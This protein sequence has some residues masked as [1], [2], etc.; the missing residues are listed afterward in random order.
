MSKATDREAHPSARQARLNVPAFI[1]VVTALLVVT[2][3]AGF[4]T[5]R[6]EGGAHLPQLSQGGMKD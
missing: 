1:G 2:T 5:L 6:G 3:A 4:L